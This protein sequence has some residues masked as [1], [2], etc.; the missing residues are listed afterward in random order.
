MGGGEWWSQWFTREPVAHFPVSQWPPMCQMLRSVPTAVPGGS[1][2]AVP[3]QWTFP[4][5]KGDAVTRWHTV[6]VHGGRPGLMG[7]EQ[8]NPHGLKWRLSTKRRFKYCVLHKGTMGKHSYLP[9]S[10]LPKEYY[11]HSE[12]WILVTNPTVLYQSLYLMIG[13]SECN[14]SL[15]FHSNQYY[16][17]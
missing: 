4:E 14:C 13:N 11:L 5:I 6:A 3:W 1:D 12:S 8:D 10:Y 15:S 16:V 17:F 9:E 2:S 7:W